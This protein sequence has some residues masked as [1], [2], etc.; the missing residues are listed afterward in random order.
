[1]LYANEVE[2]SQVLF[3]LLSNACDAID[4]QEQPWIQIIGRREGDRFTLSV[5]DSGSGIPP[6]LAER[7]MEP[8]FTTKDLGKGTGLGLSISLSIA[9]RHGGDLRLDPASSHTKFDLQLPLRPMQ[10]QA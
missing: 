8:F 3:N 2:L 1:M 6:T 5:I 10:Q 7:I 4:K 9:K